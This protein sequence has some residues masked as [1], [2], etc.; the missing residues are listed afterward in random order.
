MT[1]SVLSDKASVDE[2][3]ALCFRLYDLDANGALSSDE[4]TLIIRD[5]INTNLLPPSML[6][7]IEQNAAFV[8]AVVRNTMRAMLGV[9]V[10]SVEATEVSFEV[11]RAFMRANTR[12]LAPFTLDIEKLLQFEAEERRMERY[13]VNTLKGKKLRQII[14]GADPKKK[15]NRHWHRPSFIKTMQKDQVQS[16]NSVHNA[17]DIMR[18]LQKFGVDHS[19]AKEKEKEKVGVGPLFETG[20]ETTKKESEE[21]QQRMQRT[22]EFLYD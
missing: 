17:A 21:H 11:F 8:S 15:Y 2:K 10:E 7:V 9:D 16:V 12:L 4:L 3:C 5:A 19:D 13:S 18:D 14:I 22:I 6:R 20:S 1:M